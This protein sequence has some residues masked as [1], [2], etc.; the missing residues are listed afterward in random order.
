MKAETIQ[1]G[2]SWSIKVTADKAFVSFSL[3][4]PGMQK[5]RHMHSLVSVMINHLKYF[6]Y[7]NDGQ[8]ILFFNDL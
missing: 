2:R 4:S 6:N 7:P 8:S 5:A 1:V 3:F